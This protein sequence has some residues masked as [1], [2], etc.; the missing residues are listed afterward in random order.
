MAITSFSRRHYLQRRWDTEFE[1]FCVIYNDRSYILTNAHVVRVNHIIQTTLY[2]HLISASPSTAGKLDGS[3]QSPRHRH[4]K[5]AAGGPEQ[6]AVPRANSVSMIAV[7]RVANISRR[8]TTTLALIC[9][10]PVLRQLNRQIT[11]NL[12]H[13]YTAVQLML[14]ASVPS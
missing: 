12:S 1:N 2:A 14:S 8:T 9:N 5:H 13:L 11:I 3:L 10:Q 4:H 7:V 6:R